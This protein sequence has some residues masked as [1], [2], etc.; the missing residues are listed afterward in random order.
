MRRTYGRQLALR[1]SQSTLPAREGPLLIANLETSGR[2]QVPQLAFET[3]GHCLPFFKGRRC[4][5]E[6]VLRLA[7]STSVFTE[8][9]RCLSIGSLSTLCLLSEG[10]GNLPSA[11]RGQQGKGVVA[12]ICW[13]LGTRGG[14]GRGQRDTLAD[15]G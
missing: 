2:F 6:A 8:K 11:G 4:K 1:S 9:G 10:R 14:N 12:E 3:P 5:V 15:G 7:N 13:A